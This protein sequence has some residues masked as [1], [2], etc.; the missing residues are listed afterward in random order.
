MMRRRRFVDGMA[1]VGM[2]CC[3]PGTRAQV[4]DWRQIHIPPLHAFHPQEPRRIELSNGMVI[5]LQEAHELPLIRGTARIR[6][7]ARDEP[8]AKVGLTQ[9]FGEVW[10]TGGTQEKTGDELDDFLEARAAKVETRAGLDSSDISWNCLKD[11]F[12]E[13]FKVFVDVLQHPVFR[14]DKIALAKEQLNTGIARRN[15]DASGIAAREAQKLVYGADSPY[16]REAEY[17]TV[18]AV[19][20]DDLVKWHQHYIHPNDMILGVVGD[21]DASSMEATLRPAFESWPR[22]PV[23]PTPE[24]TFHGPKL[25]IYFIEKQDVNQSNIRM[26]GLGIRRDNPDYYA[27]EVFDQIFGGSFASRLI[28]DVRTKRGLAYAV[29]GG[30]GTAFDHPGVLQIGAGTKSNTTAATIQALYDEIDGL[31]SDPP[32]DAELKK[33]KESMLNSFVFRFDS[34]EKVLAERIGYEF[35]GYPADF[36]ER[37]RAGIEK[38]T[39][40][41]VDRAARKYIHKQQLAVLVVGNSA[42]FDKPLSAFGP[43][44]RIDLRSPEL[45]AGKQT[46]RTASNPEGKALLAEVVG[47]LG[48]EQ[49]LRSVRAV[50]RKAS[51]IAKTPQGEMTLEVNAISVYPDQIWRQ[52]QTPSGQMTLVATPA[53]AFVS[54]PQGSQNMPPSEKQEL[55]NEL[56]RDP[57]FVAQHA[58]DANFT[59]TAAGATKVDGI[60]ARILD[61]SAD[62]AEVRWFIDSRNGRILRASSQVTGMNGPAEQVL[63]YSDWKEFAGIHLACKAKVTRNGQDAGVTEVKEVQINPEVDPKLFQRPQS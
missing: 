57:I 41:D 19:T 53:A 49:T 45:S 22:G 59:F 34:K 54:M 37:Y 46:E 15:D 17:A 43:V 11:N 21:F 56:R 48:G 62:G 13:V 4:A 2:L 27:V 47:A 29:G 10:R 7:G 26:V 3:L 23:P 28:E 8:A 58:N 32:T 51:V 42:D 30:I 16:A 14:Q 6:G 36:L 52:L 12:P 18:A 20:R 50:R 40:E 5:F 55:L 25:G 9:I 61:V 35:Y 1:V 24:A 39:R 44:T 38:V 60:D 63:D 31:D 33:A